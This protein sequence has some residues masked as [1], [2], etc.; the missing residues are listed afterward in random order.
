MLK[1]KTASRVFTTSRNFA[2]GAVHMSKKS[3]RSLQICIPK[4]GLF[5]RKPGNLAN[6]LLRVY[7]ALDFVHMREKIYQTFAN[8][9]PSWR[10]FAKFP[11]PCGRSLTGLIFS[12][13]VRS[14]TGLTN[15]ET[16]PVV[17]LNEKPEARPTFHQFR[18]SKSVNRR[19]ETR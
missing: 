3:P 19:S 7:S 14:L 16:L 9:K 6:V 8:N 4:T 5:A 18:A 12:P 10:Q 11:P 1:K 13:C 2:L 15:K 17:V